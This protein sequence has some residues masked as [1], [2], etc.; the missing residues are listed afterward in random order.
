MLTIIQEEI[1][2]KPQSV[3]F[4]TTASI[5]PQN[6]NECPSDIFLQ[7]ISTNNI[8]NNAYCNLITAHPLLPIYL[9]TNNR[10]IISTWTY[11][12]ESKKSIDDFYIEKL[13]K[14]NMSKT[15]NL[16]RL[17][18]NSYGNEFLTL[19][20]NGNLYLFSFDHVKVAKLPKITLWNTPN[21]SC[22][23]ALFLNNTGVIA[24]T[25]NKQNA[26]TTLWDF[27]LPISQ[28]GVGEVNVGGNIINS[29][30]NDATMLICNDKPGMISFIDIRKMEVVNSFQA[31]LD[32]IKTIKISEKE[33]YMITG[34]K[35]KNSL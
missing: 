27:L 28:C 19:D 35:G 17:K 25:I 12:N 2:K 30:A 14:E 9:T 20:D 29:I 10:G 4:G 23:D 5:P 7:D 32:E 15:K 31:H 24:S 11:T 34:G 21:K 3:L 16:K 22:K 8:T 33:N 13:T 6:F 26:H 1:C 18:F